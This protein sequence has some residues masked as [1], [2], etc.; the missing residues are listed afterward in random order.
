MGDAVRGAGSASSGGIAGQGADGI[1]PLAA[2]EEHVIRELIEEQQL[3]SQLDYRGQAVIPRYPEAYHLKLG[4]YRRADLAL[5]GLSTHHQI[6]KALE[7]G[8]LRRVSP[9]YY[10]VDGAN[11]AVVGAIE[12]GCR[13][14][15][16][17]ACK[18]YGLWVPEPAGSHYVLA[19]GKAKIKAASIEVHRVQ[20]IGEDP[21]PSL[22]T[23]LQ[24]VCRFHD[25]ETALIV[26][27]SALNKG[28]I[29]LGD[30]PQIV[31][32]GY[33]RHREILLRASDKSQSGSETRVKNFF[34]SM[35]VP[36]QQQVVVPRVGRVDMIIGRSQII[37]CDSHGFHTAERDYHR[38]RDRDLAALRAGYATTRLS[39]QHI[40]QF[41][42]K[43]K[44][45]LRELV[46]TRQ[47]LKPPAPL[48]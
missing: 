34:E 13:L 41:W 6:T 29:A 17:S 25:P 28:L 20:K 2:F 4:V 23:A 32:Y 9:G 19:K 24:Q 27:E 18:L 22:M 31:D 30:V 10:A 33:E 38:D 37:E 43:T 36:V 3:G 47:H 48:A 35:R 21:I 26:L 15:C 1:R 39:F 44:T 12:S 7:S 14:G 45:V 11:S 42:K 46:Q 8:K 40:W 16:L 5:I